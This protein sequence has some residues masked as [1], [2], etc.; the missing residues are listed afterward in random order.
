MTQR[1][2]KLQ[3]IADKAGVS[4]M[5]VS[6]ALRGGA[7]SQRM[8]AETRE[9]VLRTAEDLNYAPNARARALRLGR[10]NVIGLYAG[11]G[12]VNVRTPFFT[13]VVSGLQEG[14]E[15]TRRDLLL[16]G[17]FHGSSPDDLYRELADGR[18]DGLVVSM[19]AEAPLA[20]KLTAS[21]L[22]AVAIAD[23]IPGMPS[24]TVDDAQ[25]MRDAAQH[26]Y[27]KGHRRVDFVHNPPYPSSARRRGEA[28]LA[29][30]HALGIEVAV[31]NLQD[32]AD[33]K[34]FLLDALDRGATAL[35]CWNDHVAHWARGQAAAAGIDVP[36]ELAIVGFDG[37]ALP[38][39]LGSS[40]TTVVAPWAEAART[41]MHVLDRMLQGE[42][43]EEEMTLPVRF[44]PGTTT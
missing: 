23:A 38:F 20:K 39:G 7:G 15:E 41:A 19:P 43:V 1:P 22:P 11:H 35:V 17:V 9:R 26:L 40:L 37:I 14:C 2:A 21:G 42:S 8:S 30:G 29:A 6:L 34:A 33:P 5:T 27:E 36:D 10:T 18:I 16:H 25:G 12:V 31:R 32:D 28:F 24:V 3:D 13:E 44:R 4:A